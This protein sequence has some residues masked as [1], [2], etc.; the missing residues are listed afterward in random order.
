MEMGG[1]GNIGPHMTTES[2]HRCWRHLS[3]E[4]DKDGT[5]DG[6]HRM[7]VNVIYG[8]VEESG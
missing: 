4:E 2:R 1:E 8:D 7:P 5:V 6:T 3:M